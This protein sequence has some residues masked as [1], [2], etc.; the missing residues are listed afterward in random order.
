MNSSSDGNTSVA[1]NI[2]LD[3]EEGWLVVLETSSLAA[4]ATLVCVGNLLVTV[5]LYRK[6]YLMTPS[7][8]L[9]M[10][11]AASNLLLSLLV[12]PMAAVCAARRAWV[13]GV[14]WCHLTALLH[15]LVSSASALTLGA[16]ALDRYYAVL[17]PM[18]YPMKITGN[19]VAFLIAYMWLHALVGSAPPLFGWPGFEFSV[20]KRMCTPAWYRGLGYAIFWQLWCMVPPFATMLI[21]Y[22]IIFRVARRKA[23]RVSCGVIAVETEQLSPDTNQDSNLEAVE[24]VQN[25]TVAAATAINKRRRNT[26]VSLPYSG[27]PCKALTTIVMVVG[28]YA[29]TWLPYLVVVMM[30]AAGGSGAVSAR[31]EALAMWLALSSA[32]CHP[33]IYGLWNKTVRKE[34][35]AMI[36]CGCYCCGGE[37]YRRDSFFQRRRTSRLFSISNRITDLGLSPHLT[38]LLAGGRLPNHGSSSGDTG[39][40]FSQDSGTDVMLLEESESLQSG[41]FYGRRHSS[42]PMD[43]L[44][45]ISTLR[46]QSRHEPVE[47]QAEVH[48]TLDSFASSLAQAIATDAKFS[49]FGDAS[50]LDGVTDIGVATLGSLL[51]DLCPSTSGQR[52]DDDDISSSSSN[53]SS[54]GG[55]VGVGGSVG[56]GAECPFLPRCSTPALLV[57]EYPHLPGSVMAVGPGS[58]HGCRRGSRTSVGQRPRLE[59]IDEGIVNDG[60][61]EEE[62]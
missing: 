9:V 42:V 30:E 32:L 15:M 13:F 61:N 10:S 28:S 53:S 18:L 57:P 49:I 12:L 52:G 60:C 29:L 50:R 34:L 20:H 25:G 43:E 11:L 1:G 62:F 46:E 27:N 3:V 37:R 19:R 4:L 39:Y 56:S 35:I 24:A 51:S 23:R 17:Y 14:V 16:I 21:C 47:V 8:R 48:S 33:L 22:G 41:R 36:C 59:S 2:T 45:L 7:N 31:A 54:G 44:P 38:S 40:S 5:T 58:V 55:S 26:T 6:P